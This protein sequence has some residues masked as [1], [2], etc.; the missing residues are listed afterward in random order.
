LD[1]EGAVQPTIDKDIG[2]GFSH[3]LASLHRW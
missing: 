1:V 3:M 2:V